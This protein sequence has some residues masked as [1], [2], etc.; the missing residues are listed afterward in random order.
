MFYTI[1]ALK[2]LNPNYDRE[3]QVKQSDFDQANLIIEEIRR[4][5]TN[6]QIQVG[7]IIE[8]TT[9]HGDYYPNTHVNHY[10]VETDTW[11]VCEWPHI[12]FVYLNESGGIRCDTG[13]GPWSEIPNNLKLVGRGQTVFKVFGHY[14][15]CPNGAFSF[16]AEVNVWQ[17]KQDNPLYGHYT[18]KDWRRFYISYYVDERGNPRN[19]SPYRYFSFQSGFGFADRVEYEVWLRTYRGVEFEG[20]WPDQTVVFCY[21]ER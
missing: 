17:Y 9:A 20:H 16:N 11:S 6:N 21:R 14:G 8:L 2:D 13:G 4:S 7:D 10:I 5:R 15:V 18:T 12:P 3:H 19:G 1:E